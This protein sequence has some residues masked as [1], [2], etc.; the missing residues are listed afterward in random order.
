MTD[1]KKLIADL[2]RDP[3]GLTDVQ[4]NVFEHLVAEIL[5]S[6][7]YKVQVTPQ[8]RDGGYDVLAVQ[9]DS[10]GIESTYAVQVK[11]YAAKNKVGVEQLRE[12]LGVKE[13]LGVSKGIL[14][15]SSSFTTD[16]KNLAQSRYDLQLVDIEQLRTWLKLYSSP[17]DQV[18]YA[19]NNSFRSCFIS[20]S[21]K[22][23]DFAEHLNT[24]LR[25]A[26]V[27]V[28]YAP[29]DMLPGETLREQIKK[30]I[31]SFDKL[32]LVLSTHS[33]QSDWVVT[34]IRDARKR[35]KEENRRVLFPIA[36]VSID[37]VKKWECF[38]S[39]TGKDLAVEIRD[40]FIPDF[41]QWRDPGVFA[42]QFTKL[43]EG[44]K[45]NPPKTSIDTLSTKA[46]A[47]L[48]AAAQANGN[49]A[50]FN[51][52]QKKFVSRAVSQRVFAKRTLRELLALYE[53]RTILQA[54]SLIEP[55]KG[56]WI[57]VQAETLMVIPDTAGVTLILTSD[58]L[59]NAR[60]DNSWRTALGRVNT[61]DKIKICGKIATIQNGQQLYLVECELAD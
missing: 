33:M 22:D 14:V 2:A 61:G 49:I 46:K 41:T 6:Q 47:I 16:A 7:G 5:A 32:L 9:T 24:S 40:F 25:S 12:L 54:D 31:R 26:G 18:P 17:P 52:P 55:Y 34:E 1:I 29:E 51:M 20:H 38:D 15:T 37:S 39:D 53:G 59:I 45:S 8:T 3:S 27:K 60:F 13:F 43:L 44:L 36:L 42:T 30:A 28:W 11:Q 48:V 21:C 4:P 10:L 50:V 19:D 56:L 57:L 35:E 23:K 58:G